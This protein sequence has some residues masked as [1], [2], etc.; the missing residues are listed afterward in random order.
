MT[1]SN[2]S[3]PP[4][5]RAGIVPVVARGVVTMLTELCINDILENQKPLSPG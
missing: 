1:T 4:A 5:R 3:P 2:D